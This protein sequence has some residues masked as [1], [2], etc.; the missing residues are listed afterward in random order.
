MENVTSGAIA[1]VAP[2][3]LST[4]SFLCSFCQVADR[5]H[6]ATPSAVRLKPIVGSYCTH[7]STNGVLNQLPRLTSTCAFTY[8]SF[9]VNEPLTSTERPSAFPHFSAEAEIFPKFTVLVRLAASGTTVVLVCPDDVDDELSPM[10]P[11][12]L[13]PT[14]SSTVSTEV[15]VTVTM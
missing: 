9:N 4:N 13:T 12:K 11:V 7:T 10:D 8:S 2:V 15:A 14:W 5:E 3:S 1:R 6:S